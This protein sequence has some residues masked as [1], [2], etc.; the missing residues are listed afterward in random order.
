MKPSIILVLLLVYIWALFILIFKATGSGSDSEEGGQ[1][2]F[3]IPLYDG[4]S[5][6][7]LQ[8]ESIWDTNAYHN[9]SSWEPMRRSAWGSRQVSFKLRYD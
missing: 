5:G 1:S 8:Y 9:S 3:S 2:F 4:G 6:T 7:S